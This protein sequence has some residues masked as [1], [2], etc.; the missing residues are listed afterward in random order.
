MIPSATGYR[1]GM[2]DDLIQ[3]FG[4]ARHPDRPSAHP[5]PAGLTDEQVAAAG[6]VSAAFEVIENARGLL[7]AF[8]RMSGK[9][10]LSLQEAVADLRDCGHAALAD[11]IDQVLIGR[12]VIPGSW[13]FQIVEGYDAHYYEVFKAVADKVRRDVGGGMPHVFEA[14]MKVAE[15]TDG[16]S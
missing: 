1:P 14:E 8:H 6:K 4:S 15:Q 7:Y 12:D 11:E 3:R 10:D 2:S 9:A 13:T 5:R 16:G